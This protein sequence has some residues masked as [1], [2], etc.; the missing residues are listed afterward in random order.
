MA[1]TRTAACADA[2]SVAAGWSVKSQRRPAA[3]RPISS[4]RQSANAQR[5]VC[6]A[7]QKFQTN[8]TLIAWSW[9]LNTH[10]VVVG[11]ADFIFTSDDKP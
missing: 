11:Y 9:A 6:P 2:I 3:D 4:L 10:N 5:G 8:L 1:A 7:A